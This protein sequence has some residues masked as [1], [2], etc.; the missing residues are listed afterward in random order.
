MHAK[1]TLNKLAENLILESNSHFS[2]SDFE[3]TIAEK[4]QQEIPASTLKKLKKKLSTHN[5]LIETSTDD[6]LPVPMVLK[7]IKNLSLSVRL[8][9]FEISKKVFFPGHRLIPFISNK[10][11]ESDLTFLYLDGNLIPKQKLPFL[12]EDIVPYYQYSNPAHFPDEIKLNNWV[13]EKSSLLITAWDIS[14]IIH[15]NQLKE[16]DYLCIKLV[17]FE[18]GIFQVQPCYKNTMQLARLKM[19]ALFV[20]MET[21]LIKL[22]AVDSFCETGLEKQL[23]CTLFHIDGHL[24][25]IPAFPLTDFIESLTELEV[26]GSEEGGGRLVPGSKNHINKLICEEKPRVSKGETGSLDMIFQDLKLAFNMDEFVSILYTIMESED[27]KLES[28]FKILFGGEGKIFNNQNQHE[29][30]YKHLRKLLKKICLDLKKPE[31]KVISTL[32]NQTVSIKLSLIEIL[33]FLEKNE[34]GLKDL[35]QDLLEKIHDLDHFCRET[36]SRLADRSVIPNL[37]FIHDARLAIKI[38]LP[39]ATSLEEEVYTQLGFY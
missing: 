1:L 16:G 28:T 24:L 11:K 21:A 31:S 37:K 4:W 19:R 10:K 26:I 30:F 12:I 14:H 17:N 34:V 2:S 7:K 27:Y 39:H 38:I 15:Q 8:N 5:Y 32:R 29:I 36:L 23:L 3:K 33:R 35:P 6:Y 9:S 18:E 25:N 20:S 22:C 13:L